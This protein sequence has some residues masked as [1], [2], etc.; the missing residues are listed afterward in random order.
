MK[1]K[2]VIAM[3][4]AVMLTAGTFFA[5]TPAVVKAQENAES[6][7][8][9][10]ESIAVDETH[11]PD[12][13]FRNYLSKEKDLDKDGVLS[14][15]EISKIEE[16]NVEGN[17]AIKSL[18]G[19]EFFPELRR[20]Y[21]GKTGI[22]ELDVSQNPELEVLYCF[23]VDILNLDI[24][25]NPKLKD[26]ECDNT[27]ISSLNL[28]N[29]PLLERIL[30]FQTDISSIDV[31]KNLNLE[32]LECAFTDITELDISKNL[33]LVTLECSFTNLTKLDVSN[34]LKLQDVFCENT[35]ITSIDVSKNQ[36]LIRFDCSNTPNMM[37]IN[38]GNKPSLD[39]I[40]MEE[41]TEKEIE[42]DG[43]TFKLQDKTDV[44][45]DLSK[46]AM[47]S[48]GTLDKNTGTVT[49]EDRTKPVVYEYDCGVSKLG[50]HTLKVTLN[51]KN[52]EET[53]NTAPVILAEDVVLNVGDSF[54]PLKNVTVTDKEDGAITLAEDNIV[55]NSVDTSK[56]GTYQVAYRVADKA[57]AVAEK[58]ITVT[59]KEKVSNKPNEVTKLDEQPAAPKTSDVASIGLC[60]SMF[61]GAF[62]AVATLV[63]KRYKK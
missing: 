62:G 35:K 43:N 4:F 2:K 42:V 49:V 37:W 27:K 10:E 58:T 53:V 16:I 25:H 12:E 21:C 39:T 52:A 38:L 8:M 22:T 30:I 36:D 56:A 44:G 29:N 20:L 50:K 9:I 7:Q 40:N 32:I 3:S 61:A 23:E 57:G 26:V 55:F 46:V 54:D 48:N 51:I 11:F 13:E 18:Q 45:I 31:S 24:T 17:E 5:G 63:K 6:M 60:T 15:D 34:N 19:I 47:I 14:K 33:N 41:A 1:L 28:E 59:V